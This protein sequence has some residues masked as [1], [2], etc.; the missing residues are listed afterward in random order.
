MRPIH[1]ISLTQGNLTVNGCDRHIMTG[2]E[3]YYYTSLDSSVRIQ[4]Q[5]EMPVSLPFVNKN[6]IYIH[7]KV[8]IFVNF[9]LT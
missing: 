9:K 3:L 2:N 5:K 7:V 1:I 4:R 8:E 6:I